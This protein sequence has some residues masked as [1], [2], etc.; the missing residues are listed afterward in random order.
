MYEVKALIKE[1]KRQGKSGPLDLTSSEVTEK[2]NERQLRKRRSQ[3]M[4]KQGFSEDEDV[5]PSSSDGLGK[6]L[7]SALGQLAWE[8]DI[9]LNLSKS[10]NTFSSS[11]T[12]GILE[13]EADNFHKIMSP[14]AEKKPLY[15]KSNKAGL[16][17]I[18]NPALELNDLS[19]TTN[20]KSIDKNFF[21][22]Q[23]ITPV[24]KSVPENLSK[25]HSA[26][27][28]SSSSNAS[29]GSKGHKKIGSGKSGQESSSSASS[30]SR[31]NEDS[32]LL[33]NDKSNTKK[34][35]RRGVMTNS[36]GSIS[37]LLDAWDDKKQNKTNVW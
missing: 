20:P 36:V 35:K 25:H 17:G 9:D 14:A 10:N 34:P 2:L 8:K 29:K 18:D 12:H 28:E 3:A 23:T 33:N 13:E 1:R 30:A 5:R 15:S 21:D 19:K 24:P 26:R 11:K 7:M 31:S 27:P 4:T 6:G 37:S 16:F 22:L 32:M